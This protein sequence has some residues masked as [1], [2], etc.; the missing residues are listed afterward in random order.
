MGI[1]VDNLTYQDILNDVPMYLEQKKQM[2]IISVNPQIVVS[3]EE[4][5]EI[6]EFIEHSTHRIPDGIGIVLVS[7]LTRG[8]I[9]QRTAG[10]DLM[11]QLLDYANENRKKCFFYGAKPEVLE[12]T[13]KR[14]GR[15][16]PNLVVAGAIN[17]YTSMEEE[18]I[19][20]KINQSQSDFLFVAMGFPRQEQW[21]SRNA[22]KLNTTVLQDVG[23]S[24]DV[25]SGFVKRA[26]DFFIKL[27]LEWLYRSVSD[28]TRIG[29]IFQLPHFLIKSLWWKVRKG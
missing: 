27:N 22:E 11:V 17:G 5:P 9:Q 8:A 18:K 19:V 10:F 29:R 1:P 28:P 26:P 4:Y 7:K 24:F 23:G 16:Y 2:T 14:I 12:N 25:L 20:E 15:D 6:I 13:V 3:A 21:L